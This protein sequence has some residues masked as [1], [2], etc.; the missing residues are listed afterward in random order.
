VIEVQNAKT[1]HNNKKKYRA[2]NPGPE[3]LDGDR[4]PAIRDEVG[5]HALD[6]L[7]KIEPGCCHPG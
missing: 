1:H 4:P 6:A 7:E 2:T 5:I 3:L